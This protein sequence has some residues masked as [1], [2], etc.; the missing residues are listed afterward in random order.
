MILVCLLLLGVPEER[1][2]EPEKK[3]RN[4]GETRKGEKGEKTRK[5]GTDN[6]RKGEKE[7]RRLTSLH[8]M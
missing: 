5:G 3:R 7:I 2:G 6:R 1:T 4:G 8:G